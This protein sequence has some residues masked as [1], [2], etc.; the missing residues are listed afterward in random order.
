MEFLDLIGELQGKVVDAA[1]CRLLQRNVE[2]LVHSN[3][4]L[5]ESNRMLKEQLEDRQE[6]GGGDRQK[7]V[8]PREA[9][10]PTRPVSEV[11]E[12]TELEGV[13]F[14]RRDGDY[15][16]LPHCP[17]CQS[18]MSHPGGRTFICRKCGYTKTLR[19]PIKRCLQ[20]LQGSRSVSQG[21]RRR[22][23]EVQPTPVG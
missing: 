4:L 6:G 16:A 21:W 1:T 10:G 11:V 20:L 9:A 12:Y 17:S 2:M 19:H 14:A 5:E 13:L 8:A 15:S 3:R 18:R 22:R 23:I 7:S